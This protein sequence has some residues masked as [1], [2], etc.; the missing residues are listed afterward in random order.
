MSVDLDKTGK[1]LLGVLVFVSLA[2]AGCMGPKET[3]KPGNETSEQ[4]F[5]GEVDYIV[6]GIDPGAGITSLTKEALKKYGLRDW[7]Q[8]TSSTAAMQAALQDALKNKEPIVVTAWQPHSVFALGDMRKLDDPKTV[9]NKPEKTRRFLKEVAPE[10]ADAP[11][12][13][14]VALTLT[15]KGFKEDAPAAYRFLKG[16]NIGADTQSQWIYDYSVEEKPASEVASE[17]VQNHRQQLDAL[18][19]QDAE[20]GKEELV[21]GSPPWPGVTVKNQVVSQVLEEMGYETEVKETDAGVVYTSLA[22]KDI[23]IMLAGW[24]PITHQEY[25][26]QTKD[27]LDVVTVNLNTTW[28]GL[29]VPDYVDEDIQSIQDLKTQ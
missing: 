15:Y 23:D 27:R 26:N 14:D 11:V 1:A 3:T 21:L 24:L 6:T 19:P 8:K 18:K 20:L 10:F 7:S 17:Y 5:G 25:Y 2:L 29:V 13:S 28:L 16:F 12:A 9:Y 4:S 22:Q